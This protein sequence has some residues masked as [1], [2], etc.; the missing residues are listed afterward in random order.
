MILERLEIEILFR[1]CILIY[2]L[3]ALENFMEASVDNAQDAKNSN[4]W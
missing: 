1:L 2:V 3:F 4:G